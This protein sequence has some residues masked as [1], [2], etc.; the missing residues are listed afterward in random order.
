MSNPSNLK[1][2]IQDDMKAAMRA[3]EQQRLDVI[4]FLLAAIK[5]REIDEKITLDDT[6]ILSVIEKQIK[7]LKDAITQYK[8][9]GRNEL[10]QKESFALEL[11]QTYMPAQLSDAELEIIIKTTI[12]ETGAASI[13][14][15]GKVMG[16]LKAKIQGQA[17]MGKVSSLVKKL[18][19]I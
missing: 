9:A 19:G 7:Q 1:N 2:R 18:L 15:M 6:Q 8:E 13:R 5:Q 4:R 14:D 10:V 3:R 16:V 11:L 12:T 17:D